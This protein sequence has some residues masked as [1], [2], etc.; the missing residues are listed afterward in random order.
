MQRFKVRL[1]AA[2]ADHFADDAGA[3]GYQCK[4]TSNQAHPAHRH[5]SKQLRHQIWIPPFGGTVLPD[6]LRFVCISRLTIEITIRAS[7]GNIT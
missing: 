6:L 3:T 7:S 5:L 1:R 4:R 2:Q